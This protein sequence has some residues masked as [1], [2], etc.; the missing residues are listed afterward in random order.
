MR[1]FPSRG[2]ALVSEQRITYALVI[3]AQDGVN[4]LEGLSDAAGEAVEGADELTQQAGGLIE[5]LQGLGSEGRSTSSVLRAMGGALR[6][7]SPE[8]G[9][10]VS[11]LG[12]MVSSLG[13]AVRVGGSFL[14]IMG[15]LTIA[16]G[17]AAAAYAVL[18]S[19]L[20]KAEEAQK[21][22]NDEATRAMEVHRQVKEA[23]LLAKLATDELT[24]AEFDRIVATQKASDLYGERIQQL[25]Q[26]REAMAASVQDS[27]GRIQQLQEQSARIAGLVQGEENLA[28][29][30]ESTRQDLDQ[31][32]KVWADR[33]NRLAEIEQKLKIAQAAEETYAS[34]LLTVSDA[35]REA[36][37]TTRAQAAASREAAEAKR[38]EADAERER[39][40]AERKQQSEFEEKRSKMEEV[41]DFLQNKYA[42]ALKFTEAA[43]PAPLEALTQAEIDL[44]AALDDQIIV[45]AE[46]LQ[47]LEN[48]QAARQA[49]ADA[50]QIAAIQA[51]G[52]TTAGTITAIGSG[53]VSNIAGA[54]VS[55]YIASG[56]LAGPAAAMA[57]AAVGILAALERLGQQVQEDGGRSIGEALEGSLDGLTALAEAI[58][59]GTLLDAIG[60]AIIDAIPKLVE[61]LP[62]ALVT[63]AFEIQILPYRIVVGLIA[64]LPDI[65]GGWADG[66]MDRLQ[67]LI[68]F[69]APMLRA[70]REW[71]EGIKPDLREL[72]DFLPFV[73]EDGGSGSGSSEGRL[74]SA[75]RG[76]WD[77]DGNPLARNDERTASSARAIANNSPR[78]RRDLANFLLAD[79]AGDPLNLAA[80]G[81]ARRAFARAQGRLSAAMAGG[82]GAGVTINTAVV[83]PNTIP[84]LNR[85]IQRATGTFG[86][87]LSPVGS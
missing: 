18:N 25:Q 40:E 14:A 50:E 77:G 54:G 33:A 4:Q 47:G 85:Q 22:A 30:R 44:K 12:S 56:A 26:E 63:L 5:T 11:A 35:G 60:N 81:G 76:I 86:R 31:E 42:E 29:A 20:K 79:G 87:V 21:R 51:A 66:I 65:L 17:A 53:S 16:L 9:A 84:E 55:T 67:P 23:A 61:A 10:A 13:A 36:A 62:G 7:I 1:P 57:T 58:R 38:D 46:Y 6:G 75:I 72:F 78:M 49:L 59:S 34:S 48:I 3:Q 8:L 74:A 2:G 45:F 82:S 39:Q 52:T 43:D 32:A 80:G 83:D 15:P 19:E 73:G 27:A 64:S 41:A 24:E 69:A 37:E 28:R 70:L 68:E 71:W